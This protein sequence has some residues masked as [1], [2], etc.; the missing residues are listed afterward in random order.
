MTG[1]S[2][3]C[4]PEAPRIR[5]AASTT[6][7]DDNR[8]YLSE[9]VDDP[10]PTDITFTYDPAGN[11]TY[12]SDESGNLTYTYD[13]LSRLKTETKNFADT[14]SS[15]PS[16]GY[17]LSYNYHLT[18]SLKSMTGPFGHQVTYSTDSIG[19]VTKVGNGTDADRYADAV[20]YRSFGSLKAASLSATDPIEIALT[21]DNALRPATYEADSA[22][23]SSKVHKASYSYQ[24][25]GMLSTVD[26]QGDAKFDQA[27]TYDFA[28]RLK[29]NAVGSSGA[30]FP[31][32]QN[33]SYNTFN[34]L[35]DRTTWT[36][37]LS[38]VSFSATYANNRKTSG[39]S[40][41]S[42]DAAGNVVSSSQSSP[43]DNIARKFDAAG[44]DRRWE[45]FGPYGNTVWKG[46]ENTYDGDGRPVKIANLT[47]TAI[48]GVWGS[49][50]RSRS[51]I[52]IRR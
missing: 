30:A 4:S 36:Y 27:N 33:L 44:R 40:F 25:D 9:Y 51:D 2:E 17:V 31:F 21:Y 15:A 38:P 13:E 45:E 35:T 19:R 28:G 37:N 26:N 41:D 29:S 3:A 39:G 5:P 34:N 11:S 10:D 46:G 20:R 32:V 16:G 47:K 43:T 42:Y 23:N 52:Y 50:V 7:A 12:M 22:A 18:G 1:C 14:L 49:W 48:G 6:A 24:K 8:L